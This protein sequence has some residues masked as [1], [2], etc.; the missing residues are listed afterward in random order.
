MV[1]SQSW[2]GKHL[3][4]DV[5]YSAAGIAQHIWISNEKGSLLVDAGDGILRDL[6]YNELD[7]D[8][9]KGVVFTHGH[10]DHM[11]GLHSLLG[12]LREMVVRKK[13]LPIYAPQGCME[14]SYI[15]SNFKK[16]YS[17]TI[18]FETSLKEIKS[19]DVFD[20]AEMSIRSFPILHCESIE[21]KGILNPIPALGYRISYQGESVAISGDTGYSSSLK[22]LVRGVDLAIIEATYRGSEGVSKEYL[23]KV[24]LSE[25]LAREIGKLA[26]DF[27]LVHRG[28]NN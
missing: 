15:V 8:T 5:L 3:K 23:E 12:Y 11:G 4:V 18:P 27:I 24:H 28:K 17:D 7:L 2:Q 1:N 25:D 21:G 13:F 20:V 16:C 22:E 6:L 9:L 14:I 26:K 10:F 19:F